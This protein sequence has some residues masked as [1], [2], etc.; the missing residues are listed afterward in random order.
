MSNIQPDLTE[1]SYQV[2]DESRLSAL[3][4]SDVVVYCSG[5][6]VECVAM[7][8]WSSEEARVHRLEN[9]EKNE[10]RERVVKE[11]LEDSR[12]SEVS[13]NPGFAF[14]NGFGACRLCCRC[15][16][17]LDNRNGKNCSE[18]SSRNEPQA[19]G[20]RVV[21]VECFDLLNH[22]INH[23]RT[24]PFI[25][26]SIESSANER[27]STRKMD[28]FLSQRSNQ[29][30]FLFNEKSE[31]L[32]LRTSLSLTV[33]SLFAALAFLW[34]YLMNPEFNFLIVGLLS[35][36]ILILTFG[37]VFKSLFV[38]CMSSIL[39]PSLATGAGRLCLVL[40]VLGYDLL[41]IA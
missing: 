22:D 33:G 28:A 25:H 9:T 1:F 32:L 14:D 35:F 16:C 21:P 11:N 19:K 8:P 30:L 40:L 23:I 39:I 2:Q 4:S 5:S 27:K 29:N 36:L 15:S 20:L 34:L 7:E 26:G 31:N 24:P 38:R 6:S 10:T 17:C 18:W 41:F 13:E 3:C 37:I 12:F